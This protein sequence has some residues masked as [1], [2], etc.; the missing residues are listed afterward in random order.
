MITARYLLCLILLTLF[1]HTHVKATSGPC[2]TNLESTSKNHSD[3]LNK[4]QQFFQ[5]LEIWGNSE[6]NVDLSPLKNLMNSDCIIQSNNTIL[7]QDIYEFCAYIHRM[8]KKY[9]KVVYS[10][11]VEDPILF[12]NRATLH[13]QVHS[14]EQNGV[15]KNLDVI[16]IVT[17]KNGKIAHWKE[18]FCDITSQENQNA[19]YPTTTPITKGYL[20]VSTIHSLF[21]ATYGN[22]KGIPVVILHGGPGEGC[23]DILTRFFD[24]TRYY[25]IMFDQRGS[26]RSVPFATLEENTPNHSVS[27]I[28]MLRKHLGFEKWLV[29]GGSYGSTLAILYGQKH[30]ERCEGFVLR[31]VFLGREEDY[32]HLLYGMGKLS[33][34]A[35]DKFL[36]YI[37]EAERFDL[38]SAYYQRILNPD[39]QV[40]RA[41]AKSFIE[42]DATC[43]QFSPNTSVIEQALTNEHNAFCVTKY[44]LHYAMNRFF[45]EPHQILSNMDRIKHLPA[46][47]IHGQYD[48]VTLPENAYTLHQKWDNSQ[49]WMIQ[50]GGHTSMEPAIASALVHAL[51]F[52]ADRISNAKL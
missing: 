42:Y 13:F 37:P 43:V 1:W 28:E 25:L 51:D 44:F 5:C 38:L 4:I 22:P 27:D 45:L 24:L 15:Q 16:A 39:E 26:H 20:P 36:K 31:G 7:S 18:V 33:P 50:K 52:F 14:I 3:A 9:T 21:Y 48:I 19:L 17:F 29:F 49:L 47:I 32:L 34:Q 30:P 11:F 35:Y 23:S 8:Q 40:R 10:N 46:I 41:A 2:S 12:D 6:T